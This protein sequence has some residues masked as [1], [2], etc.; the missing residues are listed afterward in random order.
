M[1]GLFGGGNQATMTPDYTG[2]QIQTAVNTLPVPLVWGQ[3]K[4]APNLVW[5][6]NFQT[7]ES[8]GG[9][10]SGGAKG[11]GLFS[12]STS[13]TYTYSADVILA[14]CEGPIAGINVIWKN[15]S[16]YSLAELGLSLFSGTTPQSVWGYL[17]SSDPAQALAYQGTAY[18]CA[19][20]YSLS[21]AATLDNHN[22]EVQG[23]RYGSGFG[24]TAA[25]TYVD[26][27]YPNI[28]INGASN[29]VNAALP[30]NGN[31]PATGYF[32]ADPALVIDDFLTSTQYGVGFPTASINTATLFTQGGGNDPSLQTYCRALGLA[33]SPALTDQEQASSVLQR[34]LQI[35]NTAAVWTDGQ[36]KF[37]PYGDYAVAG[38]GITFVPDVTPIYNL[39]D[40][41][42][43]AT[44]GDDPLQIS[45]SDLYEAY[46]VWRLE[47]ADRGNQYSLTTVESRDQN[48]IETVAL[49]TGAHGER[50]APTVTAHEICDPGVALISGQ[51][52]LQRAVYIRNTY[53]FRLSWEYC[54][55]DPMDLVT[56]TDIF[57]DLVNVPVRITAIEEDENGF[58]DVTAE[59][60]PIGAQTATLYAT[61]SAAGSSVDRNA[62]VGSINAPI[63][64]EPTDEL[65]ATMV[66]GG[67]LVLAAAVSSSNPL[68]GGCNV[69]MSYDASGNYIQIGSISGNARMGATTADLPPYPLNL[70]GT[71]IDQANTLAVNLGISNGVL[72]AG[73]N[74]DAI[75]LNDSC[76]VGGEVVS[77]GTA[78]LTA[79][80]AYNLTY[81][82]RGAF[83][84]ESDIVDH[85]S[86]APFAFLDN[87]IFAFPFDQSR[88]GA[89]VFLKFQSFNAFGGGLQ[90][91][92]DCAVFT[93]KITGAALSSPLPDVTDL[94]SNFEAGFQKIYWTEVVDFRGGIVYEIRQGIS[95]Q[96]G[97]FLRTQA[98]PP[99]IVPGAGTYWIAAR[100]QPVAGLI[101]YSETAADIAITG[102]QIT[103][104]LLAGY[105]E[106]AT[107]WGGLYS[108]PVMVVGDAIEVVDQVSANTCAATTSG[109]VLNFASA[110]GLTAI[111]G[112]FALDG[113]NTAALSGS[114]VQSAGYVAG[115]PIDY[116]SVASSA[117]STV[118]YGSVAS[119]ATSTIDY[120]LVTGTVWLV[121][122]NGAVAGS[123]VGAGDAITFSQA[124]VGVTNYYEIPQA[125][126]IVSGYNANASVNVNATFV[127]SPI[128]AFLG[129]ADF[130]NDPDFLGAGSTAYIDGW[131]EIATATTLTGGIPNWGGWQT[132][133]PGV[134]PALAWKF[135]AG[136]QST[137]PAAVPFC[138]T[139]STSV[140]LAARID[141]PLVN[142]TVGSGGLTIAF[143]PDGAATPAPFNGGPNSAAVP[144]V[145]IDWPMQAGDSYT[146]TSLSLAGLAIQFSN[147]GSPVA[148]SGVTI[149]VEGY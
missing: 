114:T 124:P 3:T 126:W 145:N 134:Y 86:G 91:I 36:L 30:W 118:D 89:T 55:L 131:V 73:T 47:V 20:N 64:F 24:Q 146:I 38:N 56:V 28:N 81:L 8:G 70:A 65:S 94:Y 71:T 136:L 63:I 41:D 19:A 87:K 9:K 44:E 27:I 67:G 53:K 147:G 119:S 48:A 58:L 57:L 112:F 37:I 5:Y 133:T 80:N 13:V 77:Y 116:G 25:A 33:F 78:A 40:D 123:G 109:N 92:E 23:L 142:G 43:V 101:V 60:F 99:F 129:I 21:D 12:S 102:N 72:P 22:F 31:T 42:F 6:N 17:A 59:E 66:S 137:S 107:G 111:V 61:A 139:F 140:Q 90:S 149:I 143:T 62:Q 46:N 96:N 108:P 104:N 85:P 29:L 106:V 7:H 128:S 52:M 18:V 113:T 51:L 88:I 15:Q 122:L 148:R 120:G 98:H 127:G 26:E 121:T 68:Y 95:W 34:W 82:V 50:I 45:R 35:L 105:D 49:M 141:H 125:H 2:V 103:T 132:F 1:S 69:W 93:Y 84:T 4:I 14:L 110:I 100:C 117:T 10:G 54:L 115:S 75:A 39:G 16:L 74:A 138:V 144:A 130:L 32:D 97:L 79:A 11:G 76:Y 83:G 135:R